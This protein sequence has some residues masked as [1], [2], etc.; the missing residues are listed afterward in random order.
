MSTTNWLSA[1]GAVEAEE[2]QGRK[3]ALSV[4]RQP[5]DQATRGRLGTSTGSKRKNLKDD[6][7]MIAKSLLDTCMVRCASLPIFVLLFMPCFNSRTKRNSRMHS[8]N[9]SRSFTTPQSQRLREKI[10]RLMIV[11]NGAHQPET[12]TKS[13]Q[14]VSL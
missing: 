10:Q 1:R 8:D 12:L 6:N 9:T 11:S 4:A 5:K 14:L 13:L 3:R 2:S 7:G